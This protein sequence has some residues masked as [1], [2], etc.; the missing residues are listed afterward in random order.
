[1]IGLEATLRRVGIRDELAAK[2]FNRSTAAAPV[3]DEDSGA[4]TVPSDGPRVT[5]VE[6]QEVCERLRQLTHE[7]AR[8]VSLDVGHRRYAPDLSAIRRVRAR[9]RASTGS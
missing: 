5:S 8:D 7:Q 4:V 2:P 6:C 3:L 1:M 9:M